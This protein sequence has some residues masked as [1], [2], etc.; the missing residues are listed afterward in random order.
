M[1][2]S[3]FLLVLEIKF[4]AALG[5][6]TISQPAAAPPNAPLPLQHYRALAA[7]TPLTRGLVMRNLP[8]PERGLSLWLVESHFDAKET[9]MVSRHSWRGS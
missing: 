4:G 5:D 8:N 9:D 2:P 1:D 3:A 6:A 7:I